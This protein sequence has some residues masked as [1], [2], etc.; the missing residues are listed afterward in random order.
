M[1]R[2]FNFDQV[3]FLIFFPYD[4]Y[5]V[6]FQRNLSF[7][8]IFSFLFSLLLFSLS[9]TLNVFCIKC[10][11]GSR[12]FVFHMNI[13]LFQHHVSKTFP[14]PPFIALASLLKIK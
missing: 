12:F 3:H 6:S 7:T 5:S 1:S 10:D 4:L 9:S 2:C 8:K 11:T 14:F 13:H